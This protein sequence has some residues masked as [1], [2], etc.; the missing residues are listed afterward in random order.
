VAAHDPH[1]ESVHQDMG[2]TWY[3]IADLYQHRGQVDSAVVAFRETIAVRE[4]LMQGSP[5][6][7][8]LRR[9]LA[10][11]MTNLAAELP[12]K[13]EACRTWID[14]DSMWQAVVKAGGSAPTDDDDI[15]AAHKGAA[16][17]H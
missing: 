11:A 14:S 7:A 3:G 6:A 4:A 8:A 15:A 2:N 10:Q 13:R 5:H 16:A 17:C 9:D 12:D 1:D